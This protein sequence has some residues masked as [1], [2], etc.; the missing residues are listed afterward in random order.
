LAWSWTDVV[1][2][3]RRGLRPTT[4]AVHV[5]DHD[6]VHVHVFSLDWAPPTLALAARQSLEI[7]ETRHE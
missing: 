7:S 2:A 6:H 5:H 1:V 3:E 4:T